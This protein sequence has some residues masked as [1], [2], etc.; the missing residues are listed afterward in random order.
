V[1]SRRVYIDESGDENLNISTGA[2]RFYVLAAVVVAEAHAN[3]LLD[4][5]NRLWKKYFQAGEIKS[6]KIGSNLERRLRVLAF[7]RS[8]LPSFSVVAYRVRKGLVHTDS[9]LKFPKSFIKYFARDFCRYLPASGLV[10]VRFDEKGRQRFKIEFVRYLEEKFKDD[11]LFPKKRFQVANSADCLGVQLA[12]L[13]AGSIAKLIESQEEDERSRLYNELN[14]VCC[15]WDWPKSRIWGEAIGFDSDER[16]DHVV[17]AEALMRAT[18]YVETEG[19][20]S[21]DSMLRTEFIKALIEHANYSGDDF[22]L[23]KDLES[24]LNLFIEKPLGMQ[25]LRNRVVGPLRDSGVLISSKSSR[26]DPGYKIPQS[27]HDIESYVELTDAQTIPALR[28]VKAAAQI[29]ATATNGEIDL[30]SRD[31]FA[32]MRELTKVV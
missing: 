17:R 29:V 27:V 7:A 24:R 6:S 13:Y 3:E 19:V 18:R 20:D 10:D 5:A 15:V 14:P 9:G 12:D 1:Q 32:C 31:R 16:L 28:R 23:A 2:S 22:M 21:E 8:E 26:P 4:G 11:E 25:A 30:L